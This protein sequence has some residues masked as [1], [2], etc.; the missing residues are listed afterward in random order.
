MR[1]RALVASL[2]RVASQKAAPPDAASYEQVV[3]AAEALRTSSGDSAAYA[4]CQMKL[5]KL[6]I[7]LLLLASAGIGSGLAYKTGAAPRSQPPHARKSRGASSLARPDAQG[8]ASS[9]APSTR[10]STRP[11]SSCRRTFRRG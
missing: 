1:E 11:R 2:T 10:S 5:M 4:S 9:C 8:E 3:A 6:G 7:L